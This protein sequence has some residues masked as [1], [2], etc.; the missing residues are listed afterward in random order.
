LGFVPVDDSVFRG[1]ALGPYKSHMAYCRILLP[2]LLDVPRLINLGSDVLVFRDLSKLFDFELPL[3]RFL[4]RFPI[5]KRC[6]SRTTQLLSQTLR[7]F[8]LKAF[9]EYQTH[10]RELE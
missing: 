2:H 6:H 10:A 3:A 9:H 5:R 8:P 1:A 4:Q 7:I